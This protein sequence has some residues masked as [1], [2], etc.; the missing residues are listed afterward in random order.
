VL[1]DTATPRRPKTLTL[2]GAAAFA[3]SCSAGVLDS[4]V[5]P[6]SARP[7]DRRK[8]VISKPPDVRCVEAVHAPHALAGLNQYSIACALVV[9]GNRCG[10]SR[11]TSSRS[12]WFRPEGPHVAVGVVTHF[13]EIKQAIFLYFQKSSSLGSEHRA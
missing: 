11:A 1:V 8:S 13:Q 2:F 6:S 5:T 4:G 3:G 7:L 12:T 9:A 10:I